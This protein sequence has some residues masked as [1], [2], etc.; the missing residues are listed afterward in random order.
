MEYNSD[1]ETMFQS[2]STEVS[3]SK[4]RIWKN[5]IKKINRIIYDVVYITNNS[6]LGGSFLNTIIHYNIILLISYKLQ[7]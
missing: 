4:F 7:L 3:E 1:N 5:Q 6:V 2:I